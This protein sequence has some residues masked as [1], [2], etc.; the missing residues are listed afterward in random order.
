MLVPFVRRT[1]VVSSCP[2]AVNPRGAPTRLAAPASDSV[3][4]S[5]R[6]VCVIDILNPSSPSRSRLQLAFEF[7]QKPP[8]GAVGDDFG[9]PI[10]FFPHQG[11]RDQSPSFPPRATDR[12]GL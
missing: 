1:V 3:V 11:R 4:R 7:V 8:I 12:G 5:R 10:L 6:R 2:S 9:A